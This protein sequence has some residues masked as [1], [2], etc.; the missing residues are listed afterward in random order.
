MKAGVSPKGNM[1]TYHFL[2]N[3]YGRELLLDI[4]R[5]EKIPNFNF[6]AEPH[7][8]S[9]YDILFIDK[10]TGHF[11]LDDHKIA[12][13]PGTI[14]FTSPGHTR[15]WHI[16]KPVGGYAVFFEKDFLNLFF[17]DQLFF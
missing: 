1:K 10:G 7:Q 13:K 11:M 4:G 6:G 9:F 3:K 17:T 15:E 16:R 8:L 12:L 14:I 5:I 2:P